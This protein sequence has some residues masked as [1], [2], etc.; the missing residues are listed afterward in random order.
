MA[1]ET[2][3]QWQ[4]RAL[5]THAGTVILT[6]YSEQQIPQWVKV[7]T[8]IKATLRGL[9]LQRLRDERCS[10]VANYLENRPE[11]TARALQLKFKSLREKERK[12][13]KKNMVGQY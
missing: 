12:M 6:H 7:G 3:D 5:L 11:E 10:D 13:V 8:E 4:R 2:L 1:A 9:L